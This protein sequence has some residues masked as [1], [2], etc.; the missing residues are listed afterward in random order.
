MK[1]PPTGT[2][3]STILLKGRIIM[4]TEIN[5]YIDELG[6]DMEEFYRL[7]EDERVATYENAI[8][9]M[10]DEELTE[11]E[12]A[13]KETMDY[14]Y[15]EYAVQVAELEQ[16]IDSGSSSTEEVTRAEIYLEEIE[17]MEDVAHAYSSEFGEAQSELAD[18]NVETST[19][20][21]V[22]AGS[23]VQ[24]GEEFVIDCTGAVE[25]ETTADWAED[26]HPDWLD[27]DDDGIGDTDPDAND[28]GYADEDFNGDGIYSEADFER[29]DA[30]ETVQT[31]T[32]TVAATDTVT[33]SS[34]D[35]ETGTVRF[36][37]TKEDGTVY[38]VTVKSVSGALPNIKFTNGSSL[39]S[40]DFTDLDVALVDRIYT[41]VSS[42][43][44]LAHYLDMDT[45]EDD[46]DVDPYTI[47]DLSDQED[48][49][50]S[51][52]ISDEDIE[53]GREVEFYCEDGT[54]DS[55]DLDFPDDAELSFAEGSDGE[56]I[57]TAEDAS[58]NT[59]TVTIYGWQ[60]EIEWSDSVG[61]ETIADSINITGGVIDQ[62]DAEDL[63]TIFTHW[64]DGSIGTV[65]KFE[66]SPA[67]IISYEGQTLEAWYDNET[68]DSLDT[69]AKDHDPE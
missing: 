10:T 57:I 53:D 40:E 27:T 66:T 31:I 41:E 48:N 49:S 47:V 67:S 26:D 25:T 36:A 38:Y 68:G 5:G 6:M 35:S 20:Y 4:A 52:T 11:F 42:E 61:T 59:M 33:V 15:E 30:T 54:A 62:S 3:G 43:Y 51:L 2:L 46:G 19:D 1:K 32:I 39:H 12:A 29:E 28:D 9:D 65:D 55:I 69:Y 14:L 45:G 44:S 23:D 37:I 24:S 64:L 21:T 13:L 63:A 34:Y 8:S 60:S 58:G 50:Y 16:I 18:H 7:S 56:L 17:A 22:D